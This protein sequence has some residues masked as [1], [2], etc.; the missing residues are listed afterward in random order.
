MTHIYRVA[1][2]TLWL[3]SMTTHQ[4]AV[5]QNTVKALIKNLKQVDI[6]KK[7]KTQTTAQ[8]I[9][10]ILRDTMVFCPYPVNPVRRDGIPGLRTYKLT[11]TFEANWDTPK[12]REVKK[13][14]APMLATIKKRLITYCDSIHWRAMTNKIWINERPLDFTY[15]VENWTNEEKIIIARVKRI[16]NFIY[17]GI[18]IFVDTNTICLIPEKKQK[19][20]EDLFTKLRAYGIRSELLGWHN[21]KY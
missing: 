5:G 4:K 17:K 18:G 3:L 19:M 13:R 20:L 14:N 16:P 11:L 2:L 15:I 12:V 8:G 6:H 7:W 1:I 21:E 10:Y 9:T